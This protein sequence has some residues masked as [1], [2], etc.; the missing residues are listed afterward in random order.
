M[1]HINFKPNPSVLSMV[2]SYK[3]ALGIISGLQKIKSLKVNWTMMGKVITNR[4]NV[5]IFGK[6]SRLSSNGNPNTQS[7][8]RTE[9]HP[10]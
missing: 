5:S 6:G 9:I 3:D 1:C 2:S 10:C 4:Q 7:E 8:A